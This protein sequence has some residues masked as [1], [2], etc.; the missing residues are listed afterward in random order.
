MMLMNEYDF[1]DTLPIFTEI[2]DFSCILSSEDQVRRILTICM[3]YR[4]DWRGWI[5]NDCIMISTGKLKSAD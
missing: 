3:I 2:Q 4:Q 1:S 5:N